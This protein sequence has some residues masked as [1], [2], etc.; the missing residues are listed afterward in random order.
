MTE[1]WLL[2]QRKGN[3]T[4]DGER[5][6]MNPVVLRM[7]H[8]RG[9]TEDKDIVDFIRI[10]KEK[11]FDFSGLPDIEV[12]ARHLLKYLNNP[13]AKIRIIGD[14][15]A[16]GVMSSYV[17]YKGLTAIRASGIDI[18]LPDR[19]KDG[20]G[21][22][23]R[24]IDEAKF[25]GVSLILTCDNGIAS[26]DQVE[27]AKNLGIDVIV[28]DHHEPPYHMEGETKVYDLPVCSAVIDPKLETSTCKYKEICGAVVAFK[29]LVALY[30]EAKRS[31][32]ELEYMIQ[33]LAIAT[34][35]DVMPLLDVNR[36]I[37]RIGITQLESTTN[38]GLLA[39]LNE[40]QLLGKP[41]TAYNIGFV[42]G[43]CI[44][45]AGRLET[46]DKALGLL[47]AA[48]DV[49][50]ATI[51]QDL[52][53]LNDTRKTMTETMTL[54]A[55]NMAKQ[56][57]FLN[58]KVLVMYLKDCHE[59]IAGIVA[60][61]VKDILGKPTL[62]VTDGKESLKG[63]GRSIEAYNMFE[64]LSK[65]KHLFTKF[66]G[67]SQAVGFSIIAPNFTM[68]QLQ[69]NNQ[70]ELEPKDFVKKVVIDMELPFKYINAELIDALD[71]LEPHGT[72]NTKPLFVLRNVRAKEYKL[73]GANKNV[74]QVKLLDTTSMT[75]VR[76][77]V[78]NN[79]GQF[80]ELCKDSDAIDICYNL[81]I[82]EWKGYRNPQLIIQHFRKSTQPAS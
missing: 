4:A 13:S 17:L 41:L 71:A 80:I 32:T 64:E 42:L 66:G 2:R 73:V 21:L 29:L 60:G 25:C 51:A 57:E 28:T 22:N 34:V 56:P 48:D 14:Y 3:Y 70:C 67:H 7:L 75:E 77:V 65:F 20:Y 12:G 38:R 78:F 8:N 1:Q 79:A 15:D 18:A 45:A 50:A 55:L 11:I 49:S 54:K 36:D 40:Q 26:A 24:L 53:Q 61:K 35:C 81:E 6:G 33:F 9:I 72:A 58:S 16:D 82:N 68:L 27:Y 62:I 59:S 19:H 63:S 69:L 31:W 23:K 74:C 39:L 37:L 47:L 44:N 5:L 43:P 46:A 52:K 10:N 76:G 30:R